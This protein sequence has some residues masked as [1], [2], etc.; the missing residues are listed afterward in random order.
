MDRS[1]D[2]MIAVLGV[3]KAGFAYLP[4]DPLY[5]P[6]RIRSII[7]E[8][9]IETII[10]F[11]DNLPGIDD[12]N[13]KIINMQDDTVYSNQTENLQK[14]HTVNDPAY[15]IF[16]S[17]STGKPK[18]VV[19]PHKGVTNYLWWGKNVYLDNEPLDFALHSS[20]SF[21]LTVTS[22][23]LP[24]ISG[25]R[26]YIYNNENPT[27][28]I[29]DIINDDK[30]GI[31]K[32]TPAHL[33]IIKEI[34]FTPSNLKRLIVGGEE[35]KSELAEA[36]YEKFDG[37]IKIFN[38][39]GPTEATVGCMSHIYTP[40]DATRAS[41]PI[42]APADNM[43]I[44][45]LDSSFNPVPSGA[46]GEMY[47]SGDGVAQGY[48][49]RPDLTS[50]RF[51]DNP[52]DKD[53]KLYKT[54]D[55]ARFLPDGNM[56]FLGRIDEQVKI[57]G[58]R[59]EP[60][61]TEAQLISHKD[62]SK[63]VV[64][65]K[66]DKNNEKVLCAYFV[67]SKEIKGNELRS[68]LLKKLPEYFV[69]SLF[70]NVDSI[71]LTVNGKIDRKALPDPFDKAVESAEYAPPENEKQ[72][73]LCKYWEEI[74]G[75]D[76]IGID[77]NFFTSGGH[78]LKA[79]QLVS[80]LQDEFEVSINDIFKLQTVRELD[81]KI[82]PVKD[83]MRYRIKTIKT[84]LQKQFNE[85]VVKPKPE[86]IEKEKSYKKT[87]EDLKD[88]DFIIKKQYKNILLTGATGYLGVYLLNELVKSTGVI[89]HL[90]V[91]GS[92]K[93]EAAG[94]IRDKYDY[95]FG[96]GSFDNA[97]SSV[98]VI[99][100]DITK[101]NLSIEKNLYDNL[102]SEIDCIIHSAANVK[103]FGT[104][105]ESYKT[106][107]EGTIN[108]LKFAETGSNKDFNHISTLSVGMGF[109]ENTT[110]V[111]F[112]EDDCDMG[113]TVDNV[114]LR[115]KL[116]AEKAV[117]AAREKGILTNIF[118]VGNIVYESTGTV[119]QENIEE[120][121][122]FNIISSFINL[123]YIPEDCGEYEL[124]YVDCL[125]K[126]ILS[127]YNVKNLENQIYH[128]KNNHTVDIPKLITSDNLGLNV[129]TLSTMDFLDLLFSIHNNNFV[130]IYIENIMLHMGWMEAESTENTVFNIVC[131][132]TGFI[133]DKL[134]FCWPETITQ[135]LE[136]LVLKSLSKRMDLISNIS[137]FD[138]LTSDELF[139]IA[140]FARIELFDEGNYILSEDEINNKVHILLDGIVELHKH[141]KS[142]WLGTL[143][144]AGKGELLGLNSV[145]NNTP[146]SVS[147]EVF[148]DN[149]ISLSIEGK[150]LKKVINENSELST[151]II[152]KLLKNIDGLE[153][154]VV[155]IG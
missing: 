122:F 3:L 90:L 96:E 84:N 42:G 44:Y 81:E 4:V 8:S 115:S 17:G 144:V 108:L 102:S 34:D 15:V 137:I 112:T 23:F 20:V 110:E 11:S 127:I 41:I 124:S 1:I 10:T 100:G 89:V 53:K 78:S 24:L 29:M 35:L 5:P 147:A 123:G 70:V 68:H 25:S 74:L 38:E 94:R 18:G 154:L 138:K 87:L 27:E 64:V 131:D 88:I 19:V 50:L 118:R 33:Q 13:G 30:V 79:V 73:K 98:V 120:N 149:A 58:F 45:L 142:G 80:A 86:I 129:S 146:S 2:L 76:R 72:E 71:P 141:S 36:V 101:K 26:L 37:K 32:L 56:Q 93:Q 40:D 152:E 106:N 63:A 113:Q 52:F 105:E 126:A 61:E 92:N 9:Q 119:L 28:L 91:R 6:E 75:L 99:N 85:S 62:I 132:R 7:K 60:A 43:Q 65:L 140:K 116:E 31:V 67:S 21:D 55:L 83:F 47:I 151:R 12:F 128:I 125:S 69:P 135:T 97:G 155:N 114:Y 139:K 104:Y 109:I 148:S 143:C 134:G 130:R 22:L 136:S 46:K 95:Y 16:T 82:K 57:R 66:T 145:F 117:I 133:L 103:H 54:G 49:G 153:S 48:L 59:I 107:V 150:N 39:Y 51:V 77:D 111:L 121:A 14:T